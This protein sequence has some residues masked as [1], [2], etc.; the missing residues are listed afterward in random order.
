M[1]VAIVALSCHGGML[2]YTSQ[3]ANSLAGVADVHLFTPARPGLS[4]YF[5]PDVIVH[6]TIPLSFPGQPWRGILAQANPL[7]HATNAK[8]IR[9]IAPDV[10]HFTTPHHANSLVLPLLGKPVCCTLHD[11]TVHIGEATPLRDFME[12]RAV[13]MADRVIVHGEALREELAAQGMAQERI[14]VIPHG[15]YGFLKR[16]ATGLPEEPLILFFGRFIAYKGIDVLCRAEQILASRLGGYRVCIAGEGDM[17]SFRSEIGPSGRVEVINRYLEDAEVAALFERARI[18]VL[19][20]LEAS[21]SGVLAIAFAFGKPA[22]VTRSGAL[23]EAVGMG[24]AGLIIPPNDPAAL[25][26]AIETLWNSP[27]LRSRLAEGG[28]RR[29]QDHLS[30]ERIA[31]SHLELYQGLMPGQPTPY[32]A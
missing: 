6:P 5:S 16:H 27:A 14:R 11:P 29:I 19:P 8:R 24:E 23:P 21:Q 15:D 1:R 10:V 12:R 3:L 9:R 20:Y 28:C 4:D 26:D 2:H 30:W 7:I 25:A 31:R 32:W 22:I 17:A 18:V 13:A